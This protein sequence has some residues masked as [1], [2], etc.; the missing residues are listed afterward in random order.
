[1]NTVVQD[2]VNPIEKVERS[3]LIIASTIDTPANRK[4]M[5]E[6][7]A[8]SWVTPDDIADATL[9]LC[10]DASRS[11]HGATLEVFANA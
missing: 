5:G 11:V 7:N 2:N 9:Y 3:A 8:A 6:A 1:M 4:A 10:S